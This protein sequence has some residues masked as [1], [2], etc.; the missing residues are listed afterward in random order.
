MRKEKSPIY[1]YIESVL[2]PETNDKRLSRQESE[3]LGLAAISISQTEAHLIQFIASLINPQKIV[4]IGTLT[5]LS[6]L[7][8]LELLPANG[9]L[10]TFEKSSLHSERSRQILQKYIQRGQCEIIEGD[11]LQNL[12]HISESGPFDLIF[13]DGNKAAYYEYWLWSK[14]NISPLGL[15]I[16]DNVFLAG[17]VWGDQSQQKFNE[18]Q[19]SG[20]HKMTHEILATKDFKS[21]FIPTG[22][23]LLL[24]QKIN[25]KK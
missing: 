4:E 9:K 23:G 21:T 1:S 7:Y 12:P 19:I 5:G 2:P 18:K 6:A 14:N 17:A 25:S 10:W 20:M 13:I 11:A 16:I 22:E 3:K 8:F 24:L 15:I